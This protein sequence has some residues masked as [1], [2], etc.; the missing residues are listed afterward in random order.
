MRRPRI[1]A[2]CLVWL[3]AAAGAAP[4]VPEIHS[5]SEPADGVRTVTLQEQWRIGGLDDE[6]NLLGL[7]RE[8]AMD[9]EG[10]VYLLDT[11]LVTVL[12]YDSQ[13]QFVGELGRD[14][15]GPGEF[16]RPR[17][18]ILLPDGTVGVVQGFPGSIVRIA[19]DGT[20]AGRIEL[21]GDPTEGGFFALRKVLAVGG[22]LVYAGSEITRDETK[23]S[24]RTRILRSDPGGNPLATYYEFSYE[25]EMTDTRR[26]ETSDYFPS[27][28]TVGPDGRV[29]VPPHRNEY[30]FDVYDPDGT[31]SFA[32]ERDYESWQRSPEDLEQTRLWMT[33]WGR[34]RG[35]DWEIVVEP[36]SR[37]VM[38]SHVDGSGR[39]WV[40]SSRGAHPQQD[41][42][43]SVWD[44]FDAEGHFREQVA[45]VCEGKA[46]EDEIRFVGGGMVILVRNALDA[47]LS[48][49]AQATEEEF[50][51]EAEPV[52]VVVYRMPGG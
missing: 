51:E 10:N 37:D 12:V 15:D 29:W 40:M 13:G 5:G 43:H 20:P 28:W 26:D 14:G 41:G 1:A 33:P 35:R 24:S 25:R 6:E 36:T 18:L 42:V 34:G 52:E 22:D 3:A 47:A 30:R 23:R 9:E 19:R 8:A 2:A 50:D 11:Q 17:D 21:A 49:R 4:V 38:Q 45:L 46:L 16:R 48:A 31:L 27:A 32:V 7:V 39:L 44:V